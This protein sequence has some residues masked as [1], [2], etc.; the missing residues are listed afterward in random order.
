M[1]LAAYASETNNS[2]KSTG[3]SVQ[4]FSILGNV[5]IGELKPQQTITQSRSKFRVTWR[6]ACFHELSSRV[7]YYLIKENK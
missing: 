1:S 2:L 6:D 7:F 5:L 4:S 3:I